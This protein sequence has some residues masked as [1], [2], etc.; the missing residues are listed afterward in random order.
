MKD[1]RTIASKIMKM[2]KFSDVHN[3][4]FPTE[5]CPVN[6]YFQICE[7]YVIGYS[8]YVSYDWGKWEIDYTLNPSVKRRTD[9]QNISGIKTDRELYE[10]VKSILNKIRQQCGVKSHEF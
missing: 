8:F 9:M 7:P 1:Y 2:G 5:Y 3:C 4:G 10:K 6:L